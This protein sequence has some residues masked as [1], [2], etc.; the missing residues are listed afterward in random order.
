MRGGA[1][2]RALKRNSEIAL[3]RQPRNSVKPSMPQSLAHDP[4][5]REEEKTEASG[6]QT[7]LKTSLLRIVFD[8]CWEGR[9]NSFWKAEPPGQPTSAAPP[10]R[11]M[12]QVLEARALYIPLTDDVIGSHD[13]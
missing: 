6:G 13:L 8:T 3:E 10:K 12:L 2:R 7:N 4:L 5:W 1:Q 9:L 11:Q